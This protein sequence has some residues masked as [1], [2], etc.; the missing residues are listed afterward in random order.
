[1]ELNSEAR[2]KNGQ[3]YCLRCHDKVSLDRCIDGSVS[4][5]DR[6]VIKV[7]PSVNYT[8]ELF[9]ARRDIAARDV[10]CRTTYCDP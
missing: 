10:T 8:S 5:N 1:M 9:D 4:E 3:L 6:V 2:E 7:G